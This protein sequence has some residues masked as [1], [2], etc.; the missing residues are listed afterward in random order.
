MNKKVYLLSSLFLLNNSVNLLEAKTVGVKKDSKI[1]NKYINVN[2][3]FIKK[4]FSKFYKPW[5]QSRNIYRLND[6]KWPF[7]V[8]PYKKT[9]SE[10]LNLHDNKFYKKLLINANFEEFGNISKQGIA[11]ERLTLRNFPTNKPIF[12]NPKKPGEGFPFDYNLNSAVHPNEPLFISHFSKDRKFVYVNT[13]YAGGWVEVNK[14]S[15]INKDLIDK[16]SKLDKIVFTKDEVAILNEKKLHLFYSKIGLVLP[17]IEE[18]S[19]YYKAL[20]ITKNDFYSP[21]ITIINIPKKIAK[22][23][24]FKEINIEKIEKMSKKMLGNKYGWGGFLGNR[25]CSSTLKDLF[26]TSGYWLPRNSKAISLNGDRIKFKKN[27]SRSEK[28]ALIVQKGIPYKTVLYMKG[29]IM[30]YIGHVNGNVMIFH[31]M[32]GVS[33]INKYGL[34]DKKII[35]KTVETD[36]YIGK[37]LNKR[38]FIIDALKSMTI[39]N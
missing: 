14:I 17:I 37:E 24:D 22:K 8:Y 6:I 34:Y 23:L 31:D 29:H 27:M 5:Q 11:I 38:Y 3:S 18:K 35:G 25:D 9:Y 1:V 20:F 32:W 15:V 28:E 13:S 2:N 16:I 10:N 4:F 30:L 19:N 12:Y 7:N 33:Y 39:L 36:L 26:A 21:K